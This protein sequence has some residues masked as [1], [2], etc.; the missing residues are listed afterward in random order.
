MEQKKILWVILSVSLFVLIIFGIALF[1]YSPSR[2]S[3]T[4]QLGGETIPYESTATPAP[5]YDPDLW[6]R[7]P[8]KVAGLDTAA[9]AASGNI[10]NLNN[11]N[12]ISTDG[13]SRNLDVSDLT[14]QV[15]ESEA[16]GL[17]KELAE[18]IGIETEPE[19]Q[20]EQP[21]VKKETAPRKSQAAV[22]AQARITIETKAP[23]A[24][25]KPK[26]QTP[27]KRKASVSAVQTFY[28]VQAASLANRI[29]AERARD[30]LAAQHMKVEIFTKETKTGL[31]HR[32]RVGPFNNS[33]E[34][35]YW[36]NTIK[37]IEGFENSYVSEEKVTV[38]N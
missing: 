27:A 12:I 2:N 6:A 14:A 17:P 1:L 15:G 31:T 28:W 7:D 24:A 19:V 18:Q 8:E 4:A 35:N 32:V 11:L 20:V 22:Q 37:K 26:A 33:T 10:I 29:N 34:A 5:G 30:K 16:A 23:A 25:A 38:K 21:A 36:L 3:V 9:P 13:Q